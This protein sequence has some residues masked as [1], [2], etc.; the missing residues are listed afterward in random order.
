M[1]ISL[2]K[3]F[4]FWYDSKDQAAE[5]LRGSSSIAG[6]KILRDAVPELFEKY[7]IVSMFDSGC[8]DCV[9]ASR[10]PASIVYSGGDISLSMVSDAWKNFPNLDVQVHDAT[11]DTFPAVDLIFSRD[12]VIH[13]NDQDKKKFL[14]NWLVS[15]VPWLLITHDETLDHNVDFDY[16]LHY[17]AF[18]LAP[19]NWCLSP[20]N[21]PIP[22]DKI[23]EIKNYDRGRC[24]ALWHRDQIKGLNL[25]NN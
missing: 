10:W 6:T 5:Y 9:W 17:V 2:Q 21:F 11:S 12:V 7:G 16:D 18:P 8:N 22:T 23:Y 4:S 24:M 1:N 13:F 14:Q 3:L 19:V 25:D 20:W 15:T